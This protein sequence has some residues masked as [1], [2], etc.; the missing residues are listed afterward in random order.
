MPAKPITVTN[1]ELVR[2]QRGLKALDGH[3]GKNS[4]IVRF[5]FSETLVWN[6]AKAVDIVDRE[7]AGFERAKKTLAA[8]QSIVEGQ[9]LTNENAPR[10][11][12]FLE[13][14]AAL[15][16]KTVELNGILLLSRKELQKGGLNLPNVFADLMPILDDK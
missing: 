4:E 16:E 10:V 14:I 7:V 15:E 6:S 8:Q 5:D 2:V 13:Q 9:V 11:A 12:K 3:K 1:R